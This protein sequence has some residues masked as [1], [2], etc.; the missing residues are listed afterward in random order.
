[1]RSDLGD[2]APGRHRS[3]DLMERTLAILTVIAAGILTLMLT[4]SKV[5]T[6][7]VLAIGY[8]SVIVTSLE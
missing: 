5:A 7:V 1:V 4:D 6:I 3:V 8:G 2:R